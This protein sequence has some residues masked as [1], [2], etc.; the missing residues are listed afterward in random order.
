MTLSLGPR[1]QVWPLILLSPSAKNEATC[2]EEF[3][4]GLSIEIVSTEIRL[5]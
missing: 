2:G 1:R 4:Q 3:F 5:K